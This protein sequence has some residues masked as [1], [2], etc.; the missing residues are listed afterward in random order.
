MDSESILYFSN[1]LR[2]PKGSAGARSWHQVKKLSDSFHVSVVIPSIDPVTSK[3]VTAETYDGLDFKKVDVIKISTSSNDRSSIYKRTRYYLSAM[4][5]QLRAGLKP[6]KKPSIVLCMGLPLTTLLVAWITA[7]RNRAFF[8]VDVRD[9]PFETA[10]EVGYIKSRVIIRL[11]LLAENFLLKRAD[12]ILTNSPRYKPALINKGVKESRVTVAY[13]GYDNFAE[14]SM[15]SIE[16]WRRNIAEK[17]APE[18]EFV[19]VYSGTLGH[20]FPVESILEGARLLSNEKKYGFVFLGDGQRMDEFIEAS[21]KYNLNAVFLGRVAK[22]SVASICRAVDYCIYPAHS[23]DFSAA[24]LGNKVFDYL[25][26]RKPI[27]YI[28]NDSA[29]WDLI[30]NTDSGLKSALDA[31][32]VFANNVKTLCDDNDQ[33]LNFEKNAA[34]AID[35]GKYTAQKSAGKLHKIMLGFTTASE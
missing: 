21:E 2:G 25:G 33:R 27:L 15:S 26:A 14:P 17:L 32:T 6:A 34:D 1:H 31:P 8:V 3:P 11:A 7:I 22:D 16:N 20:A 9:M 35:S 10:Y 19:G 5:G 29:V 23:G 28:G 4:K 13:I 12:H 24:I 30:S 18:T